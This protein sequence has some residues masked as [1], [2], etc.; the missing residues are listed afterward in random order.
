VVE[1]FHLPRSKH[2]KSSVMQLDIRA[3]RKMNDLVK[4]C[5]MDMNGMSTKV[6]LNIFPL[7]SYDYIIGMDRLD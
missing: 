4:S 7:G 5:P 2:G 6:D 3:K 1:I